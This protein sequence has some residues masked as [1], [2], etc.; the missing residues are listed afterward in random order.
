MRLP[1]IGGKA[2]VFISAD[3]E[4]VGGVVRGEAIAAD[5]SLELVKRQNALK[6]G[7]P[8][9]RPATCEVSRF[10]NFIDFIEA[11]FEEYNP[12]RFKAAILPETNISIPVPRAE[13]RSNPWFKKPVGRDFGA[14]HFG[15]P[16]ENS[17]SAN[18]LRKSA[19]VNGCQA[20]TTYLA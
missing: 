19:L 13:R 8:H 18:T 11:S 12:K 7:R 2:K 16:H 4:G 1:S 20:L 6:Q 5:N 14:V 10:R 9:T 15:A 3:I 17:Q